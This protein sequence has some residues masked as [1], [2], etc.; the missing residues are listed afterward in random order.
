MR[1]IMRKAE[2]N[3]KKAQELKK[4]KEELLRLR[5]KSACEAKARDQNPF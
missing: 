3:D 5:R 1:E 2:A 4:S